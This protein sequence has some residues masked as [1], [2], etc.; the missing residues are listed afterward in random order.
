LIYLNN[1]LWDKDKE[2]FEENRRLIK[3]RIDSLDKLGSDGIYGLFILIYSSSKGDYSVEYIERVIEDCFKN[4]PVRNYLS[5]YMSAAYCDLLKVAL[6]FLVREGYYELAEKIENLLGCSI[7]DGTQKERVVAIVNKEN[8]GIRI[9]KDKKGN[10]I[11][12]PQGEPMLDEKVVERTLL[13]L[14]GES[15]KEYEKALKAYA[16]GKWNES[17]NGTRRAL[18]EYLR[19]YLNNKAGL[20]ANIK[21]IGE[22]LKKAGVAEHFRKSIINQL[23]TLDSHYNSGSK[24]NSN[25]QGAVEAEYLIYSVGVIVSALEQL[26]TSGTGAL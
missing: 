4:I 1:I 15:A 24:H 14:D 25:T 17:S 23:R 20:E 6:S 13:S 9:S 21:T 26:K 7:L 8:I 11:T 2:L 3:D 12:Y 19:Q 10:Y 18:E 5:K 16:S 22:P